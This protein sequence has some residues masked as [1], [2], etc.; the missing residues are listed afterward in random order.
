MPIST[1]KSTASNALVGIWT[2]ALT[3]FVIG[4]LFFA[5]EILI[6]LALSALLTFLLSPL[7]TTIERWV[8]RIAAVLVV[9]ALIFALAG[10]GGWILTRQLVDLATKLPEYKDN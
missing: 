10:A 9:V 1:S 6:P 2:V 3:A 5:R 7:V 8:G 4:T